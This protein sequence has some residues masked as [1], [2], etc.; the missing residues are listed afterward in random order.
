MLKLALN[1]SFCMTWPKIQSAVL[2][3]AFQAFEIVKE[4][5]EFSH[6]T[7]TELRL[8]RLRSSWSK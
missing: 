2:G 1:S 8:R 7:R 5:P 6:I 4:E 3:N